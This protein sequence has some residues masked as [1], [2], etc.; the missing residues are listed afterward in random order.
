MRVMGIAH[1]YLA[2]DRTIPRGCARAPAGGQTLGPG[3]TGRDEPPPVRRT[4]ARWRGRGTAR[5]IDRPSGVFARRD[6][7]ARVVVDDFSFDP[8]LVSIPRG[9]TLRWS[10]RDQFIHDATL[11]SGPRGFATATVRH[12][13]Q[14]HRFT[15]PGEYRLY[16]SIHPVLMSQVVKV[17]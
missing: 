8:P 7:D 17:R 15:V 11:V 9:A 1:V 6:G 12:R 14:T 2:P 3:F 10:F 5:E 16:C 4:L 13:E